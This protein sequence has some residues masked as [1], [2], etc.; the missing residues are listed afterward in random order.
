MSTE[1][2]RSTQRLGK[3]M[4][5]A[6]WIIA[7]ALLTWAFSLWETFQFNPNQ[8]PTSSSTQSY[9]EI[10]LQRN[11]FNH[12]VLN[13]QINGATVTFLLDTGASDVVV[14]APLAQSLGLRRGREGLASTANGIITI[15]DTSIDSL[16]MGSIVLND[17]NASINPAMQSH[18]SILLGM[19]AL[20]DVEFTQRGDELTIRQFR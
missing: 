14:P 16:Q 5:A 11:R 18:E 3:G 19:S 15:Y 6:A 17:V 12:Y 1:H 20:K 10:V 7:L 8:Q 13:G 2:D 9:N 4:M